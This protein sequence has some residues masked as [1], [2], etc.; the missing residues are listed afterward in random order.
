MARASFAPPAP[1]R[2][3]PVA[4][5]VARDRQPGC[6]PDSRTTGC[7]V[8]HGEVDMK[9]EVAI[10]NEVVTMHANEQIAR[11]IGKAAMVDPSRI[12]PETKLSELGVDSL[13]RIECVFSIED[14]FLVEICE[15][16]LWKLRTVQDIIEAVEKALAAN[17]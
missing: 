4:K 16:D 1:S 12:R 13:A 10:Q 2:R 8:S 14:T 15:S 3:Y 17:R 5:Q 7:Y 6:H 9:R 11:I